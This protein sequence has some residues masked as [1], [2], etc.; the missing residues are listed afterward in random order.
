MIDDPALECS[1]RYERFPKASQDLTVVFCN[2]SSAKAKILP[3]KVRGGGR[4]NVLL[5]L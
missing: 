1:F 4:G 3:S 5:V 2:D